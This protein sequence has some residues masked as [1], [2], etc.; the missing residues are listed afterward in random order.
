MADKQHLPR[1][2][3]I[4]FNKAVIAVMGSVPVYLEGDERTTDTMED[5]V[6]V[7]MD[8]PDQYRRTANET[9][10]EITVDV[11]VNH[12]VDPRDHYATERLI[13]TAVMAFAD[14]VLVKRWGEGAGDD[15]SS[16]GCYQLDGEITINKFGIVNADTRVIQATIAATYKLTLTS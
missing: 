1:W 15:E 14:T 9:V 12:K 2:S 8:G 3:L 13:G 5:F 7:R 4:A 11:L 10:W 6:E 16:V